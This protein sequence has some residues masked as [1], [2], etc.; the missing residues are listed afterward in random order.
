[1]QPYSH[2][3][4]IKMILGYLFLGIGGLGIFL[5]ILPTTPFVIMS[6]AL[7]ADNPKVYA[8]LENSP[9]FGEYIRSYRE[10][11][12]VSNK[13]KAK[14][15]V[16]LWFFLFLS[17]YFTGKVYVSILLSLVGIGVSAHIIT[18]PSMNNK[19]DIKL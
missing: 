15:L 8:K 11:T 16:F 12:G 1:M 3:Q 18:L 10:G 7:F 5:P 2:K 4:K 6:A 14:S 13:T 19:E 9:Y 17:M